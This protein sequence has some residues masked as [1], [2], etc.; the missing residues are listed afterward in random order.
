M[1][2]YQ[3]IA[4]LVC[5]AV[6]LPALAAL[7]IVGMLVLALGCGPDREPAASTTPSVNPR[8]PDVP[9]PAGF[10]FRPD[11]SM[12][13]MVGGFRY[14]RHMYEGGAKV[15]QVSDFYRRGMPQLGWAKVEEN[16]SSGRQRLIFEKGN[17]TCHLSVWDD[18]GTKVMIQVM[19]KGARPATPNGS[20]AGQ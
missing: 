20:P 19:P 14:I 18:W 15:R 5:P 3:R 4:R 6:G 12:D 16:F 10:K 7:A 9:V 11:D 1:R 8:L 13:R 2:T 17:D